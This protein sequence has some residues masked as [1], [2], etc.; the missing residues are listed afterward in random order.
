M[1][2][3]RVV[4]WAMVVAATVA[5]SGPVS[6]CSEA[7]CAGC[8][9]AEGVC[10]PGS[11]NQ[12]CG[13]GGTSCQGCAGQLTC[14][15][16]ACIASASSDGGGSDDA[17]SPGARDVVG[18]YLSVQL[19]P[20]GGVV[21][22]GADLSAGVIAALVEV[23]G[24]YVVFPG[25]GEASGAF[26]IPAVPTGH[27]LL[28]VGSTYLETERSQLEIREESY[29]RPLNTQ[30]RST[31]NPTITT[32]RVTGLEAWVSPGHA[33]AMT[34]PELGLTFPGLH[35]Y[36]P[37]AFV[38]GST[39]AT[40]ALNFAGRPMVEAAKGDVSYVVQQFFSN[41]GASWWGGANMGAQLP[42]YTQL[43]GATVTVDVALLGAPALPVT[44]LPLSVDL[45]AF[46]AQATLLP[47]TQ[48]APHVEVGVHPAA[49]ADAFAMNL[50]LWFGDVTAPTPVPSYM[51]FVSP[52]PPEWALHGR[53]IHV[54]DLPLTVPG[55]TGTAWV[56]H[57][58]GVVDEAQGLFASAVRPRLGP[59]TQLTLD[60]APFTSTRTGAGKTPR[61]AW[62]APQ[63]G[64]PTT[65]YLGIGRLGLSGGQL[66]VLSSTT[67]STTNTSVLV[68][69]DV[70][71]EGNG[72]YAQVLAVS[73][74]FDRVNYSTQR[75]PYSWSSLSSPVFMP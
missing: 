50:A 1:D 63:L 7:S 56:R 19:L 20:D 39:S 43:N 4:A 2:R 36:A 72:Y 51:S 32:L 13:L 41:S 49:R 17:G 68:P 73:A 14:S 61:F 40:L 35:A 71:V 70:L 62:R 57:E 5:C 42:P 18:R 38:A 6:Q 52:F 65:Y 16:G 11:D 31:T 44:S 29:A 21:E 22:G 75:V 25:T 59:V 28:R 69:P 24:G 53:V 33:F 54:S 47:P 60:G 8:C 23:D 74:P 64:T 66:R 30:V 45:A 58:L 46:S 27:Y 67:I 55:T 3:V 10:R 48:E 37:S 9:D 12:A 26:R 34:T 15:L